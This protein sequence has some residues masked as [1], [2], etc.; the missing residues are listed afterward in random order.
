MLVMIAIMFDT[1]VIH[2][3]PWLT[4]NLG[5]R[6]LQLAKDEKCTIFYPKVVIEEIRR[7]RS[8]QAKEAHILAS[9]GIEKLKESGIDTELISEDLESVHQRIESSFSNAFQELL[10]K[11]NVVEAPVPEVSATDLL[12]RDLERRRPFAE[13]EHQGKEKSVGFRDVLIWE[14]LL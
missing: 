4:G 3:D 13:I 7:Q 6:L 1:N 12:T 2:R 8:E 11:K 14:T 10:S 5:A 9:K